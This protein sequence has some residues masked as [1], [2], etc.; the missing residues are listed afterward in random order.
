MTPPIAFM[1]VEARQVVEGDLLANQG[2]VTAVVAAGEG[3]EH[4]AGEVPSGRI[5]IEVGDGFSVTCEPTARKVI[6]RPLTGA[7]PDSTFWSP[8]DDRMLAIWT[9]HGYPATNDVGHLL[10]VTVRAVNIMR[11]WQGITA[12]LVEAFQGLTATVR[13]VLRAADPPPATDQLSLLDEGVTS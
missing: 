11:T 3:A 4:W 5:R 6:G 1:Q 12:D 10:D 8:D 2:T 9:E 7:R 13:K